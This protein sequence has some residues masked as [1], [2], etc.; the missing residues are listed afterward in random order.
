MDIFITK[1]KTRFGD[2][3][4]NY[5]AMIYK[6][7]RAKVNLFHNACSQETTISA[8]AHLTGTTGCGH[9]D[10]GAKRSPYPI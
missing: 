10:L 2:G 6:P 5:S 8:H 3:A 1:S 9:C 7:D 4:F